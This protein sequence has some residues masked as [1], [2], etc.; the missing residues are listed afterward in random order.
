MNMPDEAGNS[1]RQEVVD[2]LL[3]SIAHEE[4]ALANLLNAGASKLHAFIGSEYNFPTQPSNQ[5]IMT[6][7]KAALH[8]LRSAV[9]KDWFLLNKLEEIFAFDERQNASDTP[10]LFTEEMVEE[11]NED[12]EPE[13]AEEENDAPNSQGES[14]EDNL[15]GQDE[16]EEFFNE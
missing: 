7:N 13:V 16:P 15:G 3:G 12:T 1:T 2:Q 6:M 10:N 9:M 14:N 8:L 4:M 5:E 11:V